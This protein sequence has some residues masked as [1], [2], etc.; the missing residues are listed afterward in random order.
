MKRISTAAC[1]VAFG[2]LAL[3]GCGGSDGSAGNDDAAV[4]TTAVDATTD[5]S[6]SGGGDGSLGTIGSVPGLS[7][8]CTDL[9]NQYIKALGSMGTGENAD[10]S[11]VFTAL[12]DILPGELQ[13]DADVVADAWAKYQEVLAKYDGDV[14]KA[15]SDADALAAIQALSDEKVNAA[16][17]AIGD[18][19]SDTCPTG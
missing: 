16:S 1:I 19:F 6:A 10:I 2:A 8:E 12:K 18:Y 5:D 3:A 11:G 17:N 9:Y 14:S 15:M 13:D 7:E 4:D